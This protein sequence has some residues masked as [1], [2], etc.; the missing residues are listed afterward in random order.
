MILGI[1]INIEAETTFQVR[2]DVIPVKQI[3]LQTM[4]NTQMTGMNLVQN[5][6]GV[7][8]KSIVLNIQKRIQ[9]PIIQ[10]LTIQIADPEYKGVPLLIS[11]IAL[12]VE[13]EGLSKEKITV[14]SRDIHLIITITLL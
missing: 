11:I 14:I 12:K 13:I 9:K 4:V 10:E 2:I 1:M 3:D 7:V 5:I 8:Q 6:P